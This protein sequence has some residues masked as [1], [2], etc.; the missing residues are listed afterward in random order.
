MHAVLADHEVRALNTNRQRTIAARQ[1]RQ[2]VQAA[3][4]PSPGRDPVDV[5]ITRLDP[6]AWRDYKRLKLE[7]LATD[8]Q[9]FEALYDDQ[10]ALPDVYWRSHLDEAA[11][12]RGSWLLF[13]NREQRPV[14]MIGAF[15]TEER[16]LAEIKS[17][18]VA[19]GA[20]GRGLGNALLDAVIHELRLDRTIQA[21]KLYVNVTQTAAVD[22]YVRCG[23][24]IVEDVRATLGD[25]KAHDGYLMEKALR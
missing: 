4:S 15:V 8:P 1:R 18:F 5:T 16:R 19:P 7:A 20:R 9:A 13:A 10:R 25:G 14:G 6:G 3:T 17:V 23:F 21:V 22:L 2:A 12:S 24:S 11:N